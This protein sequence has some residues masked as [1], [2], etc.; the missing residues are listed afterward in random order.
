MDEL[1]LL[2]PIGCVGIPNTPVFRQE[3]KVYMKFG[4][5]FFKI[6]NFAV[7]LIRMF[8]KVFGDEEDKQSVEESEKRSGNGNGDAC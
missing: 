7:L 6:F 2:I 1:E 8:M 3:R 5:D 4:G